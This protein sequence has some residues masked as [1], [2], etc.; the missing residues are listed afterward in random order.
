MY[1]LDDLHTDPRWAAATYLDSGFGGYPGNVVKI[2]STDGTYWGGLATDSQGGLII[3]GDGRG[4]G[5]WCRPIWY[6]L[7][8]YKGLCKITISI[9]VWLQKPLDQAKYAMYAGP[10]EIVWVI[11]NGYLDKAPDSPPEDPPL[12]H[13]SN[14]ADPALHVPGDVPPGEWK[15]LVFSQY[16]NLADTEADP[17]ADPKSMDYAEFL[18]KAIFL[19]GL[20]EQQG[21]VD[22]A[23]YFR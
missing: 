11:K 1:S 16:V 23:L 15:D 18:T 10:S 8:K 14:F 20:N 22:L 5:Y 21:L 4:D 17:N 12:P 9:S 13:W 6:N 3:D 2:S 19:D 7:D